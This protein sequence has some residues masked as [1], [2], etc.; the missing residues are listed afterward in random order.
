MQIN[1]QEEKQD[2]QK[3]Q[4]KKEYNWDR[5]R[6]VCMEAR[7]HNQN[8]KQ[9]WFKKLSTKLIDNVVIKLLE[10]ITIRLIMEG[11]QVPEN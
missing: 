8:T 5:A 4:N 6:I 1:L 7:T 11:A 9:T 3:T 10:E 2:F